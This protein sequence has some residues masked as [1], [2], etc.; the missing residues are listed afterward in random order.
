M[1]TLTPLVAK[2]Q[3]ALYGAG[4]KASAVEGRTWSWP[5]TVTVD[6]V[7]LDISTGV[8]GT[9]T[10]WDGAT[11]AVVTTL[12]VTCGNGT[13][14]VSKAKADTAGLATALKNGRLCRWGLELDDGTDAVQGWTPSNS[15]FTIYDED[16]AP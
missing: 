8:T 9:C 7:A 4:V 3:P 16:W 11:G 5:F 14:V 12:T 1:S 6:G 15:T 13:L 2:A 10:V